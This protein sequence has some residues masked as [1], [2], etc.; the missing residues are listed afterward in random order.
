MKNYWAMGIFGFFIL[1]V[2]TCIPIFL[3][4]IYSQNQGSD[5]FF[6]LMIAML[7]GFVVSIISAIVI[8]KYQ[9]LITFNQLCDEIEKNHKKMSRNCIDE[10]Y[11]KLRRKSREKINEGDWIGFEK[12]ISPYVILF[13][14]KAEKQDHWRYLS[15]NAFRNF[16]LNGAYTHIENEFMTKLDLFYFYCDTFSTAEQDVEK[17]VMARY[18]AGMLNDSDIEIA[19]SKIERIYLDRKKQIDQQC[20]GIFNYFRKIKFW[21]IENWIFN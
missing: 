9:Y 18:Y 5:I 6:Q 7:T 8:T 12:I 10:Q 1:I 21:D 13:N 19:I 2:I 3:P 20:S 15:S 11:S 14:S 16:I 4:E 17:I